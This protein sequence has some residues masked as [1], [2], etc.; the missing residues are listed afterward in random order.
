M[1]LDTAGAAT[2]ET[3]TPADMEAGLDGMNTGAELS[4]WAPAIGG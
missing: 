2:V 4:I 1:D 3:G